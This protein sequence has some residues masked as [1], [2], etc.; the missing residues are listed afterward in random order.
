MAASLQTN[1]T[2]LLQ[3]ILTLGSLS[4]FQGTFGSGF[5]WPNG[6]GAVLGVS[7][8]LYLPDPLTIVNSST[9]TTIDL[10]GSV[11]QPGGASLALVQVT[12]IGV[13]NN[14]AANY[15]KWGPAASNGMTSMFAGTSPRSRIGPKGFDFKANPFTTAFGVTAGSADVL[16]FECEGGTNVSFTLVIVGRSA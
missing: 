10:S 7:D 5:S 13:I 2:F 9:A 4:T 6:T 12:A 3:P 1:L 16:S 8:Q 15:I 11:F 14:D